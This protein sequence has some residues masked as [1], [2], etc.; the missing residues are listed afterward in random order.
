MNDYLESNLQSKK[1]VTYRDYNSIAAV[2][3][4]ST[5]TIYSELQVDRST[6]HDLRA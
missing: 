1:E 2:E 5:P 4:V 6:Y 3:L